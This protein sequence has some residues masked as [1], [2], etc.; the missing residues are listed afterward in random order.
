VLGILKA[1]N[2]S[3]ISSGMSGTRFEVTSP[4]QE[5]AEASLER[6]L[7]E[8]RIAVEGTFPIDTKFEDG[9]VTITNREQ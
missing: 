6:V 5:E 3:Y 7:E 4:S 8:I 9:V 1:S 2:V